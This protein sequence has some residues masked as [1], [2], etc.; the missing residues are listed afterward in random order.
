VPIDMG[1]SPSPCV[2]GPPPMPR[3]SPETVTAMIAHY[4]RDRAPQNAQLEVGFFRGGVPDNAL[5]AAC[6]SLP[7]RVS[8]NPADLDQDHARRLAGSGTVVIELEALSLDPY[9]LRCCERGYTRGRLETMGSGLQSMGLSVGIHLCPGLPGSDAESVMAGVRWVIESGFV[10][11]VRIWPVLGFEGS[12]LAEW[13]AD[14]RWVPMELP[15]AVVQ[16]GQM[17]DELERAA[18]PVIRVGVQPGQDIPVKAVAGPYHPN[19][20]GEVQTRRFRRRMLD[21]IREEADKRGPGEGLPLEA[22]TIIRVHPKDIGWAKGTSNINARTLRI[23]L[24]LS[25]VRIVSDPDVERG[26]VALGK[27]A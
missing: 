11:F 16:V 20:R 14:G 10:D 6:G 21:A 1:G 15:A 22:E 19:L 4:A 13:A 26:T 2:I 27:A 9:V 18:I 25:A 3:P 7:V 23:R 17:M 8:C 24:G 5:L 12:Q